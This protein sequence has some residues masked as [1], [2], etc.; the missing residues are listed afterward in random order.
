MSTFEKHTA[1][2]NGKEIPITEWFEMES[3]ELDEDQESERFDY[4][5]ETLSEYIE[6]S[7]QSEEDQ[8]EL[9]IPHPYLANLCLK[10]LI[11]KVRDFTRDSI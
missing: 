4:C 10:V 8:A 1:N 6:N 3:F 2:I 7:S 11:D 9:Y 5:Y